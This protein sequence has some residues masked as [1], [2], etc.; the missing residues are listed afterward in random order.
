MQHKCRRR[1]MHLLLLGKSEGKRP[2]ERRRPRWIDNIKMD[3][4]ERLWDG[5]GWI[6]VARNMD[7]WKALLN[8]ITILLVS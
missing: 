5:V 3:L 4:G 8:A 6:V 2:L 7:K 1:R